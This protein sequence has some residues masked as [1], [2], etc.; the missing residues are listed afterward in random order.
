MKARRNREDW[1]KAVLTSRR[2]PDS[3]RVLLLV[4]ADHMHDN[5]QVSVPRKKLAE[6]IGRS[7]RVVS[8]R[9]RTAID[10]GLLTVVVHGYRGR[11][12]V[13]QG[14][15]PEPKS[16]KVS[17]THCGGTPY[18]PLSPVDSGNPVLPTTTRAEPPTAGRDGDEERSE[19]EAGRKSRAHLRAVS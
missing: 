8:T 10:A 18:F 3:T 12:A 4:M 14:L 11:T 7:E 13:Y 17:S 16:G 5:R 1:R 9:V 2:I 15:F 6:Q 19:E